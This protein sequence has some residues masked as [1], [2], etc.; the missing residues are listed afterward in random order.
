MDGLELVKAVRANY[1]ETG[2]P[3]DGARQRS[4]AAQALQHGAASYVP[5]SQFNKALVDAVRHV[6]DLAQADANYQRLIDHTKVTDFQFELE[7]DPELIEPLIS[8]VQ[9]MVSG[10]EMGDA[11]GRLQAGALEQAVINAMQHGNLEL[12][13]EQIKRSRT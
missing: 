13:S 10:M 6:L 12:T 7:N 3:D 8:L 4:L 5:K 1:P 9:Q 11:A 2:H